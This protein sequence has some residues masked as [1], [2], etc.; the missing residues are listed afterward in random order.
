MLQDQDFQRA[1]A[2]ST[3][4]VSVDADVD[5]RSNGAFTAVARRLVPTGSIPAEMRSFLGKELTITYTEA[6]EAP[7]GD[8]RVGTFAV[9]VAGAPGHVAGAV[10]LRPA[11]DGTEFLATG[12]AVANVPFVGAMIE[13]AVARTVERAFV[14]ELAAADAWLAR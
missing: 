3:G 7:D 11:G 4:A 13:Q 9:D 8:E 6:W 5:V 2:E 1:R 12:D 14:A 10:S